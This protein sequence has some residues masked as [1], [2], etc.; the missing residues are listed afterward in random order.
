MTERKL[1]E[2]NGLIDVI[3]EH[4]SNYTEYS[5]VQDYT[6][7]YNR[8]DSAPLDSIKLNMYVRRNFRW[9]RRCMTSAR[10][11]RQIVLQSLDISE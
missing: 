3:K 10:L 6:K 4:S 7:L 9:E 1:L 11:S 5:S 2:Y 8:N